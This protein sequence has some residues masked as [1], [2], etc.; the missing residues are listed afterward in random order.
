MGDIG[1]FAGD[2]PCYILQEVGALPAV[3]EKRY[4]SM[5]TAFVE[6][7][8]HAAP[9]DHLRSA[10]R[11]RGEYEVFTT[12]DSCAYEAASFAPG[13]LLRIKP[14]L[15]D[16]ACGH[17]APHAAYSL[18]YGIP[19]LCR[20][21][22][23]RCLQTTKD[24]AQLDRTCAHCLAD[25]GVQGGPRPGHLPLAWRDLTPS[26]TLRAEAVSPEEL[27]RAANLAKR[28][29]SAPPEPYRWE[30]LADDVF[31]WEEEHPAPTLSSADE[32]A[33]AGV[34]RQVALSRLAFADSEVRRLL[35]K[36]AAGGVGPSRL[37]ALSGVSR[38]TIPGWLRAEQ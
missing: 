35:R 13:P 4:P 15:D 19:V 32:L 5:W 34:R 12:L 14:H 30:R 33:L 37:E 9:V 21:P 20:L 17:R 22:G 25:L 10:L 36:T 3:D 6:E 8:P 28:W 23:S 18:S 16:D 26:Q 2:S 1:L 27:L 38:R 31:Q 29:K 11:R 7:W 24:E